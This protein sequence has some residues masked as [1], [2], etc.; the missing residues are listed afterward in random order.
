MRGSRGDRGD[1]G[2]SGAVRRRSPAHRC[3]EGG[4]G[5]Y[6]RSVLEA[7]FLILLIL[8]SLAIVWFS[9]FTIYRLYRGQS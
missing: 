2:A 8:A 6:D 9:V 5:R 4:V 3:D 1:P 7:T